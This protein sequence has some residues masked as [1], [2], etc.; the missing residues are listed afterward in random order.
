M[1]DSFMNDLNT[2]QRAVNRASEWEEA[3]KGRVP[4][5]R[6]FRLALSLHAGSS[7]SL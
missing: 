1:F 4:P 3:S 5:P 6:A 2:A 7:S